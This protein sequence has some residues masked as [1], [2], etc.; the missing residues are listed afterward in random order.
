MVAASCLFDA[1]V[2]Q[3]AQTAVSS[4][5]SGH[6]SDIVSAS[7][8]GGEALCLL[9]DL[10]DYVLHEGEVLSVEGMHDG[11]LLGVREAKPQVLFG[12]VPTY[13]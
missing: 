6:W 11:L 5:P 12:K 7:T 8:L 13:I 10:V 3:R 1:G 9:V 2:A 4:F